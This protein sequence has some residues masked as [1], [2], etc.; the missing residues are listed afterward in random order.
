VDEPDFAPIKSEI[1]FFMEKAFQISFG[2]V[3]GIVA[4]LAISSSN[5]ISEMAEA[6]KLRLSDL[7][8]LTVLL[9]NVVYLIL[10]CACLFAVVKRGL[11]ILRRDRDGGSVY[12]KW[13]T[14]VRG[15]G[16][17]D[18]VRAF[19]SI[20]WNIDNYYIVPL[21]VL[22][23]IISVAASLHALTSPSTLVRLIAGGLVALHALPGMMLW[24]IRLINEEC[25]AAVITAEIKPGQTGER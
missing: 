5:L 4:F 9:L 6:V 20:T 12:G 11:F 8:A 3:A 13:E 14:F 18:T 23:S 25:K 10:A 22:I 15:I 19:W 7:V 21:Y 24:S 2:Y 17:T 1:I 16:G